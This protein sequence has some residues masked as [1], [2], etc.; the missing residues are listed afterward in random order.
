[1]ILSLSTKIHTI[2]DMEKE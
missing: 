2:T 1:V